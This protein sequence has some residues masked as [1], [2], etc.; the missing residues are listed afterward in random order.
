MSDEPTNPHEAT[1]RAAALAYPEAHEDR[2]WGE[3]ALKVRGKTFMFL[4]ANEDKLGMSIKL[5]D[6]HMAALMFPFVEPTGYGLGKSG[7]ISASFAPD[8]EP[9]MGLLLAWLD[10]AYRAVA[11]K[12]L[13][14]ALTPGDAEAKPAAR[15]TRKARTV[16]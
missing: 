15:K 3:R 1:L 7:W 8:E 2:P 14:K 13:V 10:E 16:K 11:P 4:S 12:R 5:P 6:T 9:P